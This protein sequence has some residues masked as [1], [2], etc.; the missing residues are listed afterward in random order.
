MSLK[1]IAKKIKQNVT[2]IVHSV[3]KV[4][5]VAGSWV[6][7]A[8]AT[9]FLGPAGGAVSSLVLGASKGA[10]GGSAQ[11]VATTVAEGV[12]ATVATSWAVGAIDRA[13]S[14][15]SAVTGTGQMAQVFYK[16][17]NQDAYVQYPNAEN[18][19][20]E[21]AITLVDNIKAD[22]KHQAYY[23]VNPATQTPTQSPTGPG[24][25]G[26]GSLTPVSYGGGAKTSSIIL[27]IILA[28][29]AILLFVFKPWK[30]IKFATA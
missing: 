7:P 22:G 23:V 21:Q 26:R 28:I 29:L 8:V 13:T 2:N 1:S 5:D 18:I 6:V 10:S 17:S 12:T 15:Q 20:L 11:E 4:A 14:G 25:L 9:A 19:P 30:Q 27:I 16:R 3:E 24:Q